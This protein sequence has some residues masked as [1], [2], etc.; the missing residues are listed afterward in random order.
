MC[1]QGF[2]MSPEGRCLKPL[3]ESS[4]LDDMGRNLREMN[5]DDVVFMRL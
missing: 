4:G 3:Q 2:I 5:I 1:S